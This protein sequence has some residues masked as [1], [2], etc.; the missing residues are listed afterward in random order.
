[1][2]MQIY[3]LTITGFPSHHSLIIEKKMVLKMIRLK[4]KLDTEDHFRLYHQN[5]KSILPLTCQ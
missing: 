4:L 2:H 5:N 1:M 3:K